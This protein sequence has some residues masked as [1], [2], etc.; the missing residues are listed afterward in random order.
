M[1]ERRILRPRLR[2]LLAASLLAALALTGCQAIPG[3]GPVQEG[4]QSLDQADQPV[5]FTPGGPTAGA[6]QEDIVRGFV[7]AAT[8]STDD[9]AIAR[10]FLAPRY[11]EQWEPAAGVFVDEGNQ[12]YRAVDENIGEL[13]LSGLATVDERGTLTPLPP[14]PETSMRFEFEQVQ[15]EWRIVSAPNGIILDRSTFVAVWTPRQIYFLTPDNRLAAETRWFLNRAT[16]STQIVTELLA[17]PAGVDSGAMRTAFPS[18]TALI[19]NSVPVSDGTAQI[20]LSPELLTGD[21]DTVEQVKRQLATS[22]HSAPGVTR[23]EISVGGAEIESGPVTAPESDSRG[24]DPTQTVVMKDGVLGQVGP[25]EIEPLPKIGERIAAL[26]P[27]GVSLSQDRTSAA[28]RHA[29]SGGQAVS[30]VGADD[31]VT[32][33]LRAGLIDPGLDRFGYVW[34]YATSYPGSIHV[35]KPGEEGQLLE[36]PG[37]AGRSPLAVRISPAGNRIA[38]LTVDDAGRTVVIV[39]GIVREKSTRPVQLVEEP[40]PAVWLSGDPIDVDWVD[41]MRLVTLSQAGSN[42]KVTLAPLGQLAVDGGSLASAVMVS[43]GGARSMIRVLDDDG[44]LFGPQGSGWQRQS[45]G[46]SFVARST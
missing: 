33:D 19:A 7:R 21:A 4:L 31:V 22:L 1:S 45:E 24:S 9:Y 32:L 44:R 29:V 3:A 35:E 34:S 37:I 39:T 5:Q 25:G 23:F 46:V 10:E 16:L 43:G 40:V 17:G 26:S 11:A 14:G 6:T 41:E 30:W 36:L 38:M 15:G 8:S 2:G 13:S 27:L 20:D 42:V 18:G 12:P 28:V